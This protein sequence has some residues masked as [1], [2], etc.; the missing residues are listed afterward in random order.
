MLLWTPSHGRAKTGRPARTYIQQLCADTGCS[1]WKQWT[2]ETGG[3]RG[4]GRS[5]LAEWHN[6]D[7][8]LKPFNWMQTNELWLIS[9][10]LPTNYTW[11]QGG[12]CLST[13]V[14]SCPQTRH[15]IDTPYTWI[16]KEDWW[17]I[18]Q[19]RKRNLWKPVCFL[20]TK[21]LWERDEGKFMPKLWIK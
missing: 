18:G 2:I 5:M 1:Y 21:Y 10:M 3:E 8:D 7:D 12:I 15:S 19:D 16:R 14:V 11:L 13:S 9:K 4:S 20:C 17:H 6:D